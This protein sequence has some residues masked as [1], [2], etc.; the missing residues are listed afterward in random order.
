M[1]AAKPGTPAAHR[2]E[3]NIDTASQLPHSQEEVG[4]AGKVDVGRSGDE[5]AQGTLRGRE[6]RAAAAVFGVDGFQPQITDLNLIARPQFVDGPTCCLC[7][8]PHEADRNDD[9]GLARESPQ[10]REIHMVPVSVAYEDRCE[11][12]EPVSYTHLTLPT[13]YSV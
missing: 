13:I 7:D 11:T 1:A 8:F 10:G 2:Q 3:R 5:D 12:R 6:E 4:I 9:G